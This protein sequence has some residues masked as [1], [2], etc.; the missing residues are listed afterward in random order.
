MPQ[1]HPDCSGICPKVIL[2]SGPVVFWR[3]SGQGNK[4]SLGRNLGSGAKDR[5]TALPSAGKAPFPAPSSLEKLPKS[6]RGKELP[7]LAEMFRNVENERDRIP[8]VPPGASRVSVAQGLDAD[9]HPHAVPRPQ[10]HFALQLAVV[11][12]KQQGKCQKSHKSWGLRDRGT[13]AA[14]GW[15]QEVPG[16]SSISDGAKGKESKLDPSLVSGQNLWNIRFKM[17]STRVDPSGIECL[18]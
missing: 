5:A 2:I 3:S 12:E 6:P 15:L 1:I 8:W 10:L 16:G 11:W 13:S 4:I 9:Q 14:L 17:G 18:G 7:K